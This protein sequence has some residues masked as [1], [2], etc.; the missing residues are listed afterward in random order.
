MDLLADDITT[1]LS[2]FIAILG[3]VVAIVPFFK[4][5]ADNTAGNIFKKTVISTWVLFFK[6]RGFYM[7]AYRKDV[8]VVS[9]ALLKKT[10]IQPFWL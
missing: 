7:E 5:T 4:K 1:I 6:K 2:L 9:N 10:M 8:E 3:F